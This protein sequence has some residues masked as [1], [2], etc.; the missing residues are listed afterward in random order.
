MTEHS[1]F[2][3]L[4]RINNKPSLFSV[5]TASELWANEHTS[6]QMLAFHLNGEIDVSSRRTN[7]IEE[8]VAWMATRFN[9]SADS[10]LID[11]GCGPGLYTFRFAKLGIVVSGV[12]FS[13]RSI[14]YARE[15]AAQNQLQI[16]YYEADYLNFKPEGTFDLVTMIMCDFCALSPNQRL[17]MLKKFHT[18][19]A[20][21]GR[22]ILDVYSLNAFDTKEEVSIYERNMLNGF[23]S[24][25]PY[26]GFLNSFKYYPEKVS[27]DKYTIVEPSR[28]REIFNWL[29]YF[30]VETL[31]QELLA[32]GFEIE[33]V[34]KSVAGHVFDTNHSEFAIVVKKS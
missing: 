7:F 31:E 33:E 20:P 15:K 34:L 17:T 6:Q 21:K 25:E 10:K 2:S 11:F 26:Y 30:S 27:L 29:Q 14:E 12:D 24:S 5:Y 9:L 1:F 22:I 19:L 16:S 18:I 13:P 32:A 4:E 8:S 23:W 28:Q 3:D